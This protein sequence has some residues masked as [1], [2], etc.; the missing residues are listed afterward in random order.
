MYC[1]LVLW[2]SILPVCDNANGKYRPG[3]QELKCMYN[4]EFSIYKLCTLYAAYVCISFPHLTAC[5]GNTEVTCVLFIV[6]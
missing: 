4:K 1:V 3:V 6:G 2:F 5:E